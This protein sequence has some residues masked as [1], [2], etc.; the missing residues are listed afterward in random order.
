MANPEPWLRDTRTDVPAVV[1]GVLHAFDLAREDAVRWTEGFTAEQF[2]A[3][4][5]GLPSVA[6]QMRH[7]VRSLDRLLTYAE[8]KLL[9]EEQLTALRTESDAS[10]ATEEVEAEFFAALDRAAERVRAFV[11]EDLEEARSVG[12][13]HLPASLGGLLV[14]L[15]DHT[16]R[17]SGQLVTTAKVV[18]AR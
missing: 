2:H 1:R 13:K 5:H 10:V 4:P 8:G 14:H 9:S 18:R 17:H 6:F 15:A 7:M 11:G 16:Q 3:M 12:R